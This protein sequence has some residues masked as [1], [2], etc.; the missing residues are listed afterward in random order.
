MN[1]RAI[2]KL[3]IKFILISFFSL[4][5]TMLFISMA[6]NLA[7]YRT[8]VG[9]V[10]QVLRHIVENDGRIVHKLQSDYPQIGSFSNAFQPQYGQYEYYSCVFD[11]DGTIA[12]VVHHLDEQKDETDLQEYA[13][14]AL[15][16]SRT[17]GRYGT[18]Y[19][20]TGE[21]SEG[22]ALVVFIDGTMEISTMAR[23]FYWTLIICAVGLVITVILVGI[24]SR[25]MIQPE[26]ENS[27]RQKQ[28]ITNASHELKTPLAVIRANVELEEIMNGETEL[29]QSTLKQVDHMNGLIQ[30][31]V[32][33]ARA[34]EKEDK[35]GLVEEDVSKLVQETVESFRAAARQEQLE[36]V[37]RIEPELRRTMDG[38]QLRQLAT[39]L[40]DN[41]IKYCDPNGTITVSLSSIRRGKGLQLVV[42]N[43]YQEGAKVDYNRFFD[44]FYRE[45]SS[46]NIDKGGYGIGLS[47]AES[48]CK[49]NRGT[50]RAEWRD[51]EIS[52]VCRL[53]V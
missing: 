10:H 45:D 39:I 16:D 11:S 47:I 42:S 43:S 37:W 41:A 51:G 30:N 9:L 18:Y 2:Q 17:F 44:R 23:L 6:M 32:M 19:Y 12:E 25:R 7:N 13:V 38:S 53:S 15:Q 34:E 52:F 33:I 49:Q 29:S 5:I 3:R 22:D 21:T 46:H 28:F 24:F 26:I 50:I 20:Q 36:L 35:R 1:T 27:M 40:V 8:S 48:I 14:M 4:L 31:L